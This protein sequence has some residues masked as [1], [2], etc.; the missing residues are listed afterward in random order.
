MMFAKNIFLKTVFFITLFFLSTLSIPCFSV[1]NSK[2]V[3]FSPIHKIHSPNTFFYQE[4][5]NSQNENLF[6]TEGQIRFSDSYYQWNKI[7]PVIGY[8]YQITDSY[9]YKNWISLGAK[10]TLTT[11]PL[12]FLTDYYQ[13]PTSKQKSYSRLGFVYY[14]E[15]PF[16]KSNWGRLNSEN[17]LEAFLFSNSDHSNLNYNQVSAYSR[18]LYL[19]NVGP[20]EYAPYA[21]LKA[22]HQYSSIYSNNNLNSH[23]G[24]YVGLK[25]YPL[26]AKLFIYNSQLIKTQLYN[27]GIEA[28]LAVAGNF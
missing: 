15:L 12:Q 5:F 17:Y 6:L 28:L 10:Y 4:S 25:T 19:N 2:A 11:L 9:Q 22:S 18:W 24:G 13:A 21:E 23:L 14:K 20:I 7:F 8:K 27:Q 16:Q 1:E 26:S 3:L